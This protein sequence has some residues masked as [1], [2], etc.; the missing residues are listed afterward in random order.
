MSSHIPP[1]RLISIPT[2]LPRWQDNLKATNIKDFNPVCVVYR[3][4][5]F[6]TDTFM[7][8]A[9]SG[10][11]THC[12]LYIP[13]KK[14]TFAIFAGGNMECSTSLPRF[15]Q[16][17]PKDFAWHMLILTDSENALLEKWHVDMVEKKC[18]YNFKDLFWKIAPTSIQAACVSDVTAEVA[19][20]PEKM[21]CSQA[22]ILGLREAF[23]GQDT[24]PFLKTLS[25]SINS[26]ITTPSQ[27]DKHFVTY[28]HD[29]TKTSLVPM[30]FW[31]AREEFLT[32]TPYGFRR[33]DFPGLIDIQ[34]DSCRINMNN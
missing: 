23:S 20:S 28:Q 12:E 5:M 31:D 33:D 8:I 13:L 1:S 9:G 4:P 19:H 25:N 17:R 27:L 26:R 22:V 29:H 7:R 30:T 15:Y 6:M 21:F 3:R 32:N 24:K 10:E 14:A 2:P 34:S 11:F 16:S 18:H